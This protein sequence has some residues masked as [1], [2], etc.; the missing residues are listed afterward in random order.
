MIKMRRDDA[1]TFSLLVAVIAALALVAAAASLLFVRRLIRPLS[2]VTSTLKTIA[3]GGGDLTDKIDVSSRDEIGELAASFNSFSDSLEDIVI[4]VHRSADRLFGLGDSIAAGMAEA[5]SAVEEIAAN[6]ESIGRLILSQSAGVEETQATVSSIS[7]VGA[8]LRSKVGEQA[9][10]LSQSSASIAQM[11]ASIGSVAGMVER[12]SAS[13]QNLLAVSD[14]GRSKLAA[15]N[16]QVASISSQSESLLETNDV[17]ASI[18]SQTN[19]LAM[20]AAIEAAHAGDAGRGFAVVA[21]EIRKLAESSTEQSKATQRELQSIK[22]SIDLVV[23]SARDADSSFSAVFGE[24]KLLG[25]LERA[26]S[27]AVAEERV[28][29]AEVLE[30][31]GSIDSVTKAVRSG[32]DEVEACS[33]AIK[34]AMGDL[35]RITMEIRS[36]MAEIS[37][38]ASDINKSVASIASLSGDNRDTIESLR[39]EVGRFK[40]RE[41]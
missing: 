17:I 32:A 19:L 10:A 40:T 28:G 21:D 15:V 1:R 27:G 5:S 36:G 16:D 24:I 41:Y 11:V 30:S 2:V 18:A 25:D 22:S 29:S 3:E 31:L 9:T 37:R 39:S 7:R 38:G 14:D 6:V 33:E 35:I 12:L 13:L 23:E 4:G 8:E 34:E 20:N 26:V